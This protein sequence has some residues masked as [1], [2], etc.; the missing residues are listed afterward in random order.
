MGPAEVAPSSHA[1]ACWAA[2]PPLGAARWC[3]VTG[4]QCAWG[5][6][7]GRCLN[8]S[9]ELGDPVSPM[10]NKG[11]SLTG[12]GWGTPSTSPWHNAWLSHRCMLATR[13]PTREA[14][15]NKIHAQSLCLSLLCFPARLECAPDY[16]HSCTGLLPTMPTDVTWRTI[17]MMVHG[18][19]QHHQKQPCCCCYKQASIHSSKPCHLRKCSNQ[20]HEDCCCFPAPT[21]LHVPA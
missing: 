17:I 15:V 10:P 16:M 8:S 1:R 3:W 13:A 9:L 11:W 4:N 12:A 20:R 21:T 6:Q 7:G 5:Q 19:H 18:R 2:T 14:A